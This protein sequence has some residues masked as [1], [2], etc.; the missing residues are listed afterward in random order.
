MNDIVYF[1]KD[2]ESN[3][4]LRYSL[5]SLVNF[6]HRDVWTN[7]CKIVSKEKEWKGNNYL[8][9]VDESFR[10]GVVGK[11]IR[12]RFPDKCKYES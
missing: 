12:E 6:P 1:V 3:E 10:D 4:E 9:T 7:D 5:R 11:Q 8:S 2:S